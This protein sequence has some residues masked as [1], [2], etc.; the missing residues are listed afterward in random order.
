MRRVMR[1]GIYNVLLEPTQSS[2]GRLQFV[3]RL[4]KQ[5]VAVRRF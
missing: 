5:K 2:S 3:S 4:D 1:I